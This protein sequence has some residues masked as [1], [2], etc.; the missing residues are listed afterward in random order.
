MPHH[1]VDRG[2]DGDDRRRLVRLAN[3]GI[4]ERG[5]ELLPRLVHGES[6]GL[7]FLLNRIE[8]S[9]DLLEHLRREQVGDHHHPGQLIPDRDQRAMEIVGQVA[10]QDLDIVLWERGRHS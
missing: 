5:Q 4:S 7:I 3:T 10:E 2:V 8:R 1:L 6:A 9:I